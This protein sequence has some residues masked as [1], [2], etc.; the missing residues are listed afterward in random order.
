MTDIELKRELLKLYA[1]DQ[2]N[3]TADETLRATVIDELRKDR[4]ESELFSV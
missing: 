2:N 3:G 1:A 4:G